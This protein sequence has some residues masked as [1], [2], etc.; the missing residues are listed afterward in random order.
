MP[1]FREGAVKSRQMKFEPE[2]PLVYRPS[3]GLDA[4]QTIRTR[5]GETAALELRIVGAVDRPVLSVGG[6]EH[7]FDAKLGTN[8]VLRCANGVDWCVTRVAKGSRAVVAS[9]RLERPIAP[10]C[11]AAEIKMS[12]ADAAHANARVSIAKRYRR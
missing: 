2:R 7:A 5:P 4:A 11:G 1:A 10:F 3:A 12:A 9:G 8:D 6:V